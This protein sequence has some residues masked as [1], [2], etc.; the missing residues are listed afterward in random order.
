MWSALCP[1][2]KQEGKGVIGAIYVLSEAQGK[3]VGRKLID[4]AVEFLGRDRPITLE[5]ASYNEN[6]IAFYKHLGFEENGNLEPRDMFTFPSGA[7]VPEIEMMLPANI[8]IM[9][10]KDF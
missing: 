1:A 3:G 8:K 6:A 7:V 5:V 4:K 2:R 10:T 9:T